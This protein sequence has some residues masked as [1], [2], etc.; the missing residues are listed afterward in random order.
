M[1]TNNDL[2]E[3]SAIKRLPWTKKILLKTEELARSLI[4][5]GTDDRKENG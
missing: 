1:L 5:F 3:I 2:P 4:E